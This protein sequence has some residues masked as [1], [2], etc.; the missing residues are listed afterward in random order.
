MGIA[1]YPDNW[2]VWFRTAP[3]HDPVRLQYTRQ[4]NP[5]HGF[6]IEGWNYQYHT[7][8]RISQRHRFQTRLLHCRRRGRRP[9]NRRHRRRHRRPRRPRFKLCVNACSAGPI[10]RASNTPNLASAPRPATLA[11]RARVWGRKGATQGRSAMTQ[12]ARLGVAIVTST[13]STAFLLMRPC[14]EVSFKI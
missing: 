7:L 9:A 4:T 8:L 1:P 12:A 11:I 10:G 6:P 14:H 2:A 13:S 3:P 5:M